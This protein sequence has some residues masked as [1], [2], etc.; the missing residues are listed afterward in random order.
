MSILNGLRSAF[1]EDGVLGVVRSIWLH[2]AFWGP[3]AN[4]VQAIL[5]KRLQQMLTMFVTLGYWPN[6]DQ[7]SSFN[8]KIVHRKLRTNKELFTTVSDKVA[9]RE[10]VESKVNSEI[11]NEVYYVTKDPESIPFESLPSEFVVKA[12]HSSGWNKIIDDKANHDFDDLVTECSEW[13]DNTFG[14]P[15][16]EYWYWNIE[17]KILIERRMHDDEHG[18]PI[19]YKFFVFNGEV[20]YIQVDFDRYGN[21]SRSVFDREWNKLDLSL[22]FPEGPQTEP[23]AKL[24][25]MIDVAET[26]GK[27]FDFIRVDLY[28]PNGEQV[29]FGELTVGPGSGIERFKPRKYDFEFGSHW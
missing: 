4:A 9:V 14:K 8:E 15:Q 11:L 17:P 24:P 26:L 28:Q 16:A 12:N 22:Q 25:E 21:H 19:D 1:N 13:L 6:I 7:P 23:P 5:G 10:Y 2:V 27:E 3:T 18:I 29:V 20:E